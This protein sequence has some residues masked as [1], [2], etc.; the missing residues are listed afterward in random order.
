MHVHLPASGACGCVRTLQS[1][2]AHVCA[3]CLQGSFARLEPR[4]YTN[5][6]KVKSNFIDCRYRKLLCKRRVVSLPQNE[7]IVGDRSFLL[8]VL[9]EQ[10]IKDKDF[11]SCWDELCHMNEDVTANVDE[12]SIALRYRLGIG[13]T[14]NFANVGIPTGRTSGCGTTIIISLS[15]RVELKV[16]T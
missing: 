14:G 11:A 6:N 4:R 12:L 9:G 7:R 2:R 16:C 13:E 10:G 8:Q 5:A 3:R 15:V 1:L